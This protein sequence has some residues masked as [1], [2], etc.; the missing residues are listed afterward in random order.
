MLEWLLS[1][2]KAYML[3]KQYLYKAEVLIQWAGK[4]T[5]G[6]EVAGYAF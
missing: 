5:K 3:E 4:N 2:F 6:G 1:I